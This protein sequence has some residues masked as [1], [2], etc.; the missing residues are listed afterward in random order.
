MSIGKQDFLNRQRI[1][2]STSSG[3]D[4]VAAN[5]TRILVL[6]LCRYVFAANGTIA[7]G[8]DLRRNGVTFSFYEAAFRHFPEQNKRRDALLHTLAESAYAKIPAPKLRE[9]VDDVS[10]IGSIIFIDRFG[11]KVDLSTI[12]KHEIDKHSAHVSLSHMRQ[13]LATQCD[14]MIAFGGKVTAKPELSGVAKEV[15]LFRETEKPLY[16]LGGF[17]GVCEA[18][19]SNSEAASSNDGLTNEQRQVLQT[20]AHMPEVVGLILRGLRRKL[21]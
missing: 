6:E 18:L 21:S 12:R 17:G 19:V 1:W 7:Y 16:V 15:C 20:S 13:M 11:K 8:G 9:L 5:R 3:R 2:I 4:V 10:P 14:A